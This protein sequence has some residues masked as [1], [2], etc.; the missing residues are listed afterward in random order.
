MSTHPGSPPFLVLLFSITP[1]SIL[2]VLLLILFVKA[3]IHTGEC[4]KTCVQ[5]RANTC[6]ATPKDK[7]YESSPVV[8]PKVT[9]ILTFL[10]T[11]P[12]HFFL[13]LSSVFAYINNNTSFL[14][15]S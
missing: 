15:L 11:I 6:V 5:L 13:V 4:K 1:I 12:L 10:I 8:F 2:H 3:I 14:Y 7:K 9:T